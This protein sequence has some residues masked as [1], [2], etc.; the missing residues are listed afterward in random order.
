MYHLV[1]C[2]FPIFDLGLHFNISLKRIVAYLVSK[3]RVS[4]PGAPFFSF[5]GETEWQSY[6]KA[7]EKLRQYFNHHC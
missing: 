6:P 1:R 7:N 2:I 3:L 4:L 5:F